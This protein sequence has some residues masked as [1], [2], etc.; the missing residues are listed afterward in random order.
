MNSKFWL[1]GVSASV[2]F[3]LFDGCGSNAPK[4]VAEIPECRQ[5]AA[6]I[7]ESKFD[8]ALNL[9]RRQ[10]DAYSDCMTAH[11]YVIDQAELDEQLEHVRQVENAKWMGGDPF[12]IIA[13]RRQQLRMSP[14]LW[15]PAPRST[16]E[17]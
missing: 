5:A 14:V 16:T 17:G 1:W 7:T 4:G 9:L 6:S 12:Y 11:G 2:V 13:K 8:T 15:H 3:V 10:A